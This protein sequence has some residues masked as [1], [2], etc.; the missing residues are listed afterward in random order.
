VYRR[1]QFPPLKSMRLLEVSDQ[2]ERRPARRGLDIIPNFLDRGADGCGG[3]YSSR[4]PGQDTRQRICGHTH[5][6]VP[7]DESLP[8][9]KHTSSPQSH[10]DGLSSRGARGDPRVATDDGLSLPSAEPCD[11]RVWSVLRCIGV[12]SAGCRDGLAPG[13]RR[14]CGGRDAAHHGNNFWAGGLVLVP[15]AQDDV[16]LLDEG[17]TS[18]HDTQVVKDLVAGGHVAPNR[19]PEA[20]ALAAPKPLPSHVRLVDAH[21]RLC[22]GVSIN[23]RR[24]QGAHL[25]HPEALVAPPQHAAS[26]EW[27]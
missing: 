22:V 4:H 16:R 3:L 27:S 10:R 20:R 17:A 21:H 5:R 23:L 24:P 6:S 2:H 12:A 25:V 8:W 7:Q 26:L 11:L 13:H 9:S 19:C 15:L 18:S 14:G 1:P